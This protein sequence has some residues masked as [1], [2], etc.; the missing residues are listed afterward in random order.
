M[1]HFQL[2]LASTDA[3]HVKCATDGQSQWGLMN[4]SALLASPNSLQSQAGEGFSVCFKA[5]CWKREKQAGLCSNRGFKAAQEASRPAAAW[6]RQSSA[7]Y[8]DSRITLLMVSAQTL[9]TEFI[10]RALSSAAPWQHQPQRLP[11]CVKHPLF[12][13]PQS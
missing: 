9:F 1:F 7:P 2:T 12:R 11:Q 5:C 8:R 4:T 10:S 3:I 6:A 13:V